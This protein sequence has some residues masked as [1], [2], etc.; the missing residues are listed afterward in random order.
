[1]ATKI[2]TGNAAPVADVWTFTVGGT[3]EATDIFKITCNS[4]VLSVVA[5]STSAAT[6]AAN[7]VAAW[8]A[9]S[10]A[11]YP[12]FFEYTPAVTSGG[13]FTATAKTAGIPGDFT[14]STTETGGG[15]AD[16]Q[17]FS[18]SNSTPA[19]GPNF[20]SEPK[21]WVNELGA[22]A[23]PETGDTVII[24]N[25]NVS[26]LY[27]IDQDSVQ[28][29]SLR[30]DSTFTGTIGLPRRNSNSYSEYRLQYL[31]L[32]GGTYSIG[33]GSG[34]GSG[35]IKI[36]T[37]TDHDSFIDVFGTGNTKEAGVPAFLWKGG[38][39]LSVLRV[40]QGSVG[41]AF[42]AG[43]SANLSGGLRVGYETS[44]SSDASVAIGSG[45]TLTA[46]DQTGGVLELNCAAT[47]VNHLGGTFIA[48]GSGSITTVNNRGGLFLDES[49]GTFTTVENQA[50]YD[51]RRVMSP[52]TIT[53]LRVYGKSKTWIPFGVTLTNPLELFGCSIGD[54]ELDVGVHKKLTVAAI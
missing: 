15:A 34:Q 10:Q 24:E 35:R 40:T 1:M 29:S 37:G 20:W 23:V 11:N 16:S 30:I 2:W 3:I 25:S 41:A 4:K 53:T 48:R 44:I 19:T 43:E 32:D 6:V 17:T 39:S 31:T 7:I 28:L 51:R 8:S 46:V 52:K 13:A 26:I 18:Y 38:E 42:F 33:Q 9:L 47:T 50:E 14:A 22:N 36:N 27:G 49:S 12:E 21:N 45:A 5:G 54:V